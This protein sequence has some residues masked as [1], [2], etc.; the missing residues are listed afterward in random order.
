M[1]SNMRLLNM[2]HSDDDVDNAIRACSVGDE[3]TPANIDMHVSGYGQGCKTA[4]RASNVSVVS[5]E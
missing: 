4:S 1:A 5:S 2:S 3:I